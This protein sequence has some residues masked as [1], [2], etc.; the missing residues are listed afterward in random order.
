LTNGSPRALIMYRKKVLFAR[1][2]EKR[3]DKGEK[4]K[5]SI[6]FTSSFEER[7]GGTLHVHVKKSLPG[8]GREKVVTP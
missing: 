6:F 1:A 7:G 3:E 4:K 5:A 2:V 8:R